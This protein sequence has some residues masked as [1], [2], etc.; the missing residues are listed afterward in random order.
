MNRLC[1]RLAEAISRALEADEREAVLGDLA[2]S[3]ARG[4]LAVLDVLN[5]VVRR[6][7]AQWRAWRPWLAI[8]VVGPLGF[9]LLDFAVFVGRSYHL[10]FW[11]VQ[12]YAVIDPG[13]LEETGLTLGRGGSALACHS[14]LL[15]AWS[16]TAGMTLA[17]LSRRTVGPAATLLILLWFVVMPAPRPFLIVFAALF[18]APMSLGMFFGSRFDALSIRWSSV[19]AVAI[20]VLTMLA[21]SNG[22]W[23]HGGKWRTRQLV[24]SIILSGPAWGLLASSAA[25]RGIHG[26][27]QQRSV[28]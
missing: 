16:W 19:L 4:G 7:A 15:A 10:Y 5:L 17:F 21:I 18:A 13:A 27:A 28:R 20:A 12:N 14:F 3:G 2:E 22:D 6:Q 26:G 1:W 11:I 25:Q 23:W 24:T 9:L 8:A